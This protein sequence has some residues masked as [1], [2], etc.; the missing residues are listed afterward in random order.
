VTPVEE[1][2]EERIEEPPPVEMTSSGLLDACGLETPAPLD[3]VPSDQLPWPPFFESQSAT[4]TWPT[5][6]RIGTNGTVELPG[7]WRALAWLAI[8][9]SQGVFS[10]YAV[11]A[12]DAESVDFAEEPPDDYDRWDT[13]PTPRA[14]G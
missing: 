1:P 11:V 8:D 12:M 2:V 6:P 4:T 5:F 10:G 3:Y 14:F 9:D 13:D 7:D